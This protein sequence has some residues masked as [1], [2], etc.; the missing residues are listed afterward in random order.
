MRVKRDSV[1]NPETFAFV[2]MFDMRMGIESFDFSL[3]YHLQLQPRQHLN[4][5]T[6]CRSPSMNRHSNAEPVP[7]FL[8]NRNGDSFRNLQSHR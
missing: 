8:I 6:L 4:P 5:G 7:H 2:K 3:F 1:G